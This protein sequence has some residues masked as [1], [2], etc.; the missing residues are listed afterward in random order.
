MFDFYFF[1][2]KK[3][4]NDKSVLLLVVK[5]IEKVRGWMYD[6]KRHSIT[7]KREE[8]VDLCNEVFGSVPLVGV[9][10]IDGL[11][12][13]LYVLPKVSVLRVSDVNDD[14]FWINIISGGLK[15]DIYS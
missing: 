2:T 15:N 12:F 1:L 7:L 13:K 5:M 10:V 8:F 9:K 3:F 6:E 11:V 4:I 14:S